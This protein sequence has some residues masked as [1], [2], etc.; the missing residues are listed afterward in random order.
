MKRLIEIL[1]IEVEIIDAV[2]SR[3]IRSYLLLLTAIFIPMALILVVQHMI[4]TSRLSD[5]EQGLRPI[6]MFFG[7]VLMLKML[8]HSIQVY[9][10]DRAHFLQF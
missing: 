6:L 8:I 1:K 3:R 5:L 2:L 7:L 4:A 10:K 9:L